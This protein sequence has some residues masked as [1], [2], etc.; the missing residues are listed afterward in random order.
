MGVEGLQA[1]YLQRAL[2]GIVMVFAGPW[3][4]FLDLPR[5]DQIL[6]AL[7][8]LGVETRVRW[9]PVSEYPTGERAF[10]GGYFNGEW[11]I[12]FTSSNRA[13]AA[14][15]VGDFHTPGKARATHFY[16]PKHPEPP[17]EG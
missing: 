9:R 2:K 5:D 1:P 17:K 8:E 11:K 4:T 16:I 10:F 14:V 3:P 15:F 7:Q 13:E 12:V 6:A